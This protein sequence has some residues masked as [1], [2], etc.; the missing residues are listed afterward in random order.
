MEESSKNVSVARD[1]TTIHC[2]RARGRLHAACFRAVTQTDRHSSTYS[3]PSNASCLQCSAR[4]PEQG[5]FGQTRRRSLA[6]AA[7]AGF[8]LQF[9][10]KKQCR[11]IRSSV[12]QL[13]SDLATTS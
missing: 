1:T 5:A 4:A 3:C 11:R 8:A 7:P 9:L 13:S 10:D 12:T 2:R 6:C